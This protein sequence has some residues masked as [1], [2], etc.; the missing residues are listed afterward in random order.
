M[1]TA[2]NKNLIKLFNPRSVAVVGAAREA[3]K[4]GHIIVKNI[5]AGGYSGEVYPVNPHASEVAGRTVMT[6]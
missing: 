1:K 4:I 5:V 2:N 3:S 6:L